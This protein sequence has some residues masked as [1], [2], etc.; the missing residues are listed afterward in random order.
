M[1]I[2][3][4]EGISFLRLVVVG[5]VAFTSTFLTVI[6]TALQN[7]PIATFDQLKE[8][9]VIQGV[10]AFSIA[11]SAALSAIVAFF[12]RPDKA[13]PANAVKYQILG[14]DTE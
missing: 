11:A 8:V 10:K 7:T 9:I 3:P 13:L 4:F 14:K 2:G 1:K 12:T 6:A 5:V